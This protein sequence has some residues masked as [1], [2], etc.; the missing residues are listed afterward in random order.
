MNRDGGK[1][2]PWAFV[3]VIICLIAVLAVITTGLLVGGIVPMLA[4][5]EDAR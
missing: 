3:P 5:P 1:I 4:G 2:E